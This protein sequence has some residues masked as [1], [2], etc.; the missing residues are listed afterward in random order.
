MG[1]RSQGDLSMGAMKQTLEEAAAF[2]FPKWEKLQG[3]FMA[4]VVDGLAD[5]KA[6]LA[7]ARMATGK[8]LDQHIG[9]VLHVLQVCGRKLDRV[10]E[11][12]REGGDHEVEITAEVANAAGRLLGL[13]ILLGDATAQSSLSALDAPREQPMLNKATAPSTVKHEPI[14]K[15]VESLKKLQDQPDAVRFPKCRELLGEAAQNLHDD[16]PFTDIE[17]GEQ[18]AKP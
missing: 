7:L 4:N 16:N 3:Q 10:C 5:Q 8:S 9:Q 2:L 11:L 18:E 1:N 15:F 12:T 13:R 6:V 17:M 14:S